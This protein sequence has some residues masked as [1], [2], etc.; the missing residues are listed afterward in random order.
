MFVFNSFYISEGVEHRSTDHL[1][2]YSIRTE[3]S[4]DHQDDFIDEDDATNSQAFP[5]TGEFSQVSARNHMSADSTF[6]ATDSMIGVNIDQIR[7]GLNPIVDSLVYP[8]HAFHVIT[9]RGN[10]S[11]SV[12][13]SVL[14][15]YP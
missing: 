15:R 3:F 2:N 12:F 7:Q 4:F 8:G 13:S 14:H 5:T 11:F 6:I 10:G 9:G 1:A